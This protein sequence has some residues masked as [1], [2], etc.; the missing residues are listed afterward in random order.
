MKIHEKKKEPNKFCAD[1]E[2]KDVEAKPV[3]YS[4]QPLHILRLSD[5]SGSITFLRPQIA[6][7]RPKCWDPNLE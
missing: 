7:K 1:V 5:V 3:L 6:G 2:A 4:S